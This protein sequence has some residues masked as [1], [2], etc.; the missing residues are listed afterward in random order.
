MGYTHYCYYKIEATQDTKKWTEFVEKAKLVCKKANEWGIDL[1]TYFS[2]AR[3][4]I[5]GSDNQRL[6][7]RVD[8]GDSVGTLNR[9]D[10]KINYSPFEK[11]PQ[12]TWERF[13]WELKDLPTC[14]IDTQKQKWRWSYENMVFY[15]SK[16]KYW[17]SRNG[18]VFT[19]CKTNFRPYD[20]VVTALLLLFEI[21]FGKENVELHSDWEP[22]DWTL[23]YRLL[24]SATGINASTP[25]FK[26][27]LISESYD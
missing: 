25:D 18:T 19:F 14:P 16:E 15:N 8:R 23:W 2:D 9:P 20:I 5:N 7:N 17:D 4:D 26:D 3:V 10:E 24:Q 13:G 22:K 6:N 27:R 21:V 1:E 12:T 11:L